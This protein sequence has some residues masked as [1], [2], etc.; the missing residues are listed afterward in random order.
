MIKKKYN[1]NLS[2]IE[3]IDGLKNH[4]FSNFDIDNI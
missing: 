3:K 2:K 1:Y 4:I